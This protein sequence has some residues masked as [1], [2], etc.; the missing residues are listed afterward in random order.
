MGSGRVGAA[1]AT[2]LDKQGHSVAIIDSNPDAFRKLPSDFSGKK[3]KGIGFDRD[4]LKR[5]HIEEAY[6][7][8]AI[9][10][11]DN[12][13]ILAAR[14]ARETFAV[15]NVVARIYDPLRADAYQR[16][17]IP[18]TS[19]VRW[20][21]SEILRFMLPDDTDILFQDSQY[22]VDLVRIIPHTSW[23]SMPIQQV[24]QQLDIKIGYIGRNGKSI[25]NLS[26]LVIQE[27]DELFCCLSR[28]RVDE[29]RRIFQHQPD[30]EE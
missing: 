23:I 13:N 28:N 9:T 4:V 15:K 20:T 3:I 5:A 29:I 8:A 16:L 12:S 6:A 11:G 2:I 24:Q 10:S 18:T 25:F 21:S 19:P 1:V 7:F 14:I 27:N 30:S 22:A 26:N 17:G